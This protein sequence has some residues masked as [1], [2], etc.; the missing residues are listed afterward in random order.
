MANCDKITMKMNKDR[1]L[2]YLSGMG[3]KKN[4]ALEIKQN[5]YK[6]CK[7]MNSLNR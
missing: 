2:Q 1:K 6:F 5:S 3:W 4:S 7:E